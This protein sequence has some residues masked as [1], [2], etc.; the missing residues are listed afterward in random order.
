MQKLNAGESIE[1]TEKKEEEFYDYD[2]ENL[3]ELYK[4]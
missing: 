2:D 4:R 3:D 1:Q